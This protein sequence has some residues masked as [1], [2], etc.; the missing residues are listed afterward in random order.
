M[1]NGPNRQRRGRVV[2]RRSHGAAQLNLVQRTS[3]VQ[4]DVLGLVTFDFVLRLIHTCMVRVAFV[5]RVLCV[6][7]GDR[8]A[9]V[10]RFRI[11]AHVV[12]HFKFGTNSLFL[13]CAFAPGDKAVKRRSDLH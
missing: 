1:A 11:P 13:P 5:V 7:F 10:A 6:Y 9:D 2:V 3:L 8:A 4:G 12:A